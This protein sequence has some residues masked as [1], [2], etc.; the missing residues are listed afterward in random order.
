MGMSSKAYQADLTAA[1]RLDPTRARA[2]GIRGFTYEQLGEPRQGDRR[3]VRI[4]SETSSR[5]MPPAYYT[6]GEAYDRKGEWD[7]AIADFTEGTDSN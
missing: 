6:R 7:N 4:H 3:F 5:I 2:Y 1:I